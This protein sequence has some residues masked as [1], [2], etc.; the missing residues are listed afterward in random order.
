MASETPVPHVEMTELEKW[1]LISNC[2]DFETLH[3][4]IQK[5]SNIDGN[6]SGTGSWHYQNMQRRL[7]EVNRGA[8]PIILTR[9]Y[10]IRRQALSLLASFNLKFRPVHDLS[11]VD[12]KPN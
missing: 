1:Q 9:A 11:R 3:I 6:I 4:A 8:D 12:G 5:V 2:Y 10:G 7:A